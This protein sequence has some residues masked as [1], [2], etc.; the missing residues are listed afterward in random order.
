MKN[1][2]IALFVVSLIACF[3]VYA[4]ETSKVEIKVKQLVAKY[5]GV[6]GVDCNILTKGSDLGLV[7]LMIGKEMKG[8]TA[9]TF[10]D[11]SKA[12]PQ[13]CQALRDDLNV[14]ISMLQEFNMD[15]EKELAGFDYFRCFATQ[16]TDNI[17]SDIMII[18]ENKDS[19]ILMYM[20]GKIEAI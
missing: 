19:K 9:I 11:Y 13:T 6:K 15:N 12:S 1:N 5:E 3:S 2:I 7:K 16:L 17:A 4:Q 20:A 8:V 18:M 10:F 14:I